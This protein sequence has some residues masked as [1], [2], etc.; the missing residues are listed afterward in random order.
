MLASQIRHQANPYKYGTCLVSTSENYRHV[1]NLPSHWPSAYVIKPLW[2]KGS[3]VLP[4]YALNISDLW[5]YVWGFP[6][7]PPEAFVSCIMRQGYVRH[8]AS[9]SPLTNTTTSAL[10][11]HVPAC[12]TTP[13]MH[14]RYQWPSP[15]TTHL[16]QPTTNSN[17]FIPTFRCCLVADWSPDSG[18]DPSQCSSIQISFLPRG[19]MM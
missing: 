13:I 9:L 19:H 11:L 7:P 6:P 12:A 17:Y 1:S 10:S 5:L 15:T 3:A 8:R 16:M 14:H 2:V 4:T 18:V